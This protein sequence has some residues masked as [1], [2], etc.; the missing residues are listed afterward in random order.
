[1]GVSFRKWPRRWLHTPGPGPQRKDV[2]VDT[3]RIAQEERSAVEEELEEMA[4]FAWFIRAQEVCAKTDVLLEEG[5]PADEV[6]R[7]AKVEPPTERSAH[8]PRSERLAPPYNPLPGP[9][10]NAGD[11][12]SLLPDNI[13]CG[14]R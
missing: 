9:G 12:A 8:G 13:V 5:V 7:I 11:L 14:R 3:I 2:T 6:R 10:P 4:A 1:M